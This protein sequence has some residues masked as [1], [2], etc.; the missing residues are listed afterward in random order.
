MTHGCAIAQ[1]FLGLC[2]AAAVICI[3]GFAVREVSSERNDRSAFTDEI[4]QVQNGL[5]PAA[6]VKGIPI[7]RM[8]LSDRM[9]VYHVTGVS[10]AVVHNGSIAWS[11]G[12]GVSRIGGSAITADTLFQAGSISKPVSAFAALR[13]VQSGQIELNADVNRYLKSWKL[14]ANNLTD[15]AESNA[16]RTINAHRRHDRSRI[17]RLCDDRID[18]DTHAGSE[19]NCPS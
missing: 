17:S 5:L 6:F 3:C 11:R 2:A 15:R 19:R 1:V 7:Q 10:I 16:S 14:P 4:E 18:S 13:L 12:F 8:A 9:F